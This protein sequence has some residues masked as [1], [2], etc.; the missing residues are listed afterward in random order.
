MLN[1]LRDRKADVMKGDVGVRESNCVK[2]KM[3]RRQGNQGV[4]ET[5]IDVVQ[6]VC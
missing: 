6:N 2:E 3:R 4:A 5:T 1:V